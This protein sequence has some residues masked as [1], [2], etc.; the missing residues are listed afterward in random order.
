[1]A[2]SILIR[3]GF[4]ATM[5]GDEVIKDGAVHVSDGVISAVGKSDELNGVRA[6]YV[7]D[8]SGKIVV[9]GFI[10]AHNH[11][12][13]DSYFR[14]SVPDAPGFNDFIDYLKRFK[15][16]ILMKMNADDYYLSG[17]WGNIETVKAGATTVVDNHYA[18][19]GINT[20]G[21]AQAAL[22]VGLRSVLLKAYHDHPYLVPEAF[23]EPTD[24]LPGMYRDLYRRWHGKANGRIKI[25]VGP[26]NLLYSTPESIRALSA[27]SEELNLPFHTHVAEVKRGVDAIHERFG[28]GYIEVFHGLGAVSPRFQAAHGIWLNDKEIDILA[29]TKASVIHN[30]YSNMITA[31][32]VAPV[33]ALLRAGVN[34]ALGSDTNLDMFNAM[35]LAVCLHKITTLNAGVLDARRALRMA[36]INGAKSLGLQDEIGSLE[37][38]KKADITL[39]NLQKLHIAPVYDPIAAMVYFAQSSD[40]D[41]VIVD[42]EIIVEKGRVKTVDEEYAMNRTLRRVE[43]LKSSIGL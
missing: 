42:G 15:W 18:P 30:P 12:G 28:K 1:M 24:R 43:E 10:N 9:P 19:R 37:V 16:P 32:G 34:V 26:I 20:E 23:L 11:T 36:T 38:G 31:S 5:K 33:P 41:A 39:V 6:E 21:V 40:V 25:A 3:H 22:E 7:I 17:L 13:G 8:A 14:S 2:G 35:R 4:V 27:L 29:R